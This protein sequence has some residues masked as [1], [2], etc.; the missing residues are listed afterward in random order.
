MRSMDVD[1]RGALVKAY[2]CLGLLFGLLQWRLKMGYKARLQAMESHSQKRKRHRFL[3][4][5]IGLLSLCSPEGLTS[6]GDRSSLEGNFYI[7]KESLTRF[8]SSLHRTSLFRE[9]SSSKFKF[10]QNET[11]VYD[12]HRLVHPGS[13]GHDA[14]PSWRDTEG[15]E[16]GIAQQP[17]NQHPQGQGLYSNGAHPQD[18]GWHL[19]SRRDSL[20]TP[21]PCMVGMG[22]TLT[23][24]RHPPVDATAAD[25][26]RIL[27]PS[28]V[29]TA[30]T[31]HLPISQCESVTTAADAGMEH[32]L[33][34]LRNLPGSPCKSAASSHRGTPASAVISADA[35]GVLESSKETRAVANSPHEPCSGTETMS[36]AGVAPYQA[37]QTMARAG[38]APVT[39]SPLLERP[40][41]NQG[42]GEPAYKQLLQQ[43]IHDDSHLKDLMSEIA[44]TKSRLEA[45]QGTRKAF[46]RTEALV[47]E[48]IPTS[49]AFTPL[50]N[51]E[52]EEVH[53]AL[54]GANRHQVLVRHE[55]SNIDLS[56]AALQCLKPGAWLNDE[57]I[58]LYMELLKE[59]ERREQKDYLKCHFF[60]T[61]FFNKLYK[62]AC[63]YDFKAVRRWTTQRKLGYSLL[64]CDKIFV[65]IHKDIHWCLAVI[66]VREKRIQYLD[67]L[68]GHDGNALQVLARYIKDEAKDKGAEDVDIGAWDLDCPKDIP[69]QMNGC[70]CGMFMIKYADFLS[71]GNELK[72]TQEHMEYFR[73]RTAL[74]LLQLK[75]R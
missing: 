9:V 57:V 33:M 50:S 48:E 18:S 73:K 67:S 52:E 21:Q 10:T 34:V 22:H 68:K 53:E 5:K 56:R 39:A 28:V 63:S 16:Q 37:P 49:A 61:F 43:R 23:T 45:L 7:Q 32:K 72:F 60:N 27:Q 15:R 8:A 3:I 36:A 38:C 19:V 4:S 44:A 26:L 40:G 46:K 51:E 14:H 24:L 30:H 42:G 66:N 71:R 55:P 54:N 6:D 12:S 74:E 58:N 69:Q 65:P 31:R 70:D 35:A 29:V 2:L 20:K 11:S 64:E 62:D 59:R 1:T 75:A 17:P 25:A 13:H 41:S 47:K